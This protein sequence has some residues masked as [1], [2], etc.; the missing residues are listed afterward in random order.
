MTAS[1]RVLNRVILVVVGLALIAAGVIALA[2]TVHLVSLPRLSDA[3]SALTSSAMLWSIAGGAAIVVIASLAWI[4][5]R[6]RGHT[7]RL[8]SSRKADGSVQFDRRYIEDALSAR[9]SA[10]RDVSAVSVAAFRH[11]TELLARLTIT[12]R[13]GSDIAPIVTAARLSIASLDEELGTTVPIIVHLVPA[14]LR[15]AGRAA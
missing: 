7:N 4:V 14:R 6:G 3:Q 13:R 9:L 11:R 5:T 10:Q 12:V 15:V 8:I 1:N 2:A